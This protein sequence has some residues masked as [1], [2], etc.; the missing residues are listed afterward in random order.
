MKLLSEQRLFEERPAFGG[1][2]GALSFGS[3]SSSYFGDP[4]VETECTA[5]FVPYFSKVDANLFGS[6][7]SRPRL[8]LPG[9]GAGDFGGISEIAFGT[10]IGAAGGGTACDFGNLPGVKPQV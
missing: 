7:M 4:E 8:P 5:A 9:G 10:A 3:E 2:F 1:G 6:D